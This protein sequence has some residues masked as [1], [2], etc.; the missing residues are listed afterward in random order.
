MR[1][2]IE[3]KST[4]LYGYTRSITTSAEIT[5]TRDFAFAIKLISMN[6]TSSCRNT[7]PL[8]M[9]IKA[10]K[11]KRNQTRLKQQQKVFNECICCK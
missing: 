10:K 1:N 3:N 11:I 6:P 8:F 5:T 4:T 7:C 2:R 9:E